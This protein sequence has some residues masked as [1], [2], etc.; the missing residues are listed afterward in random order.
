MLWDYLYSNAVVIPVWRRMR[1]GSDALRDGRYGGLGIVVGY[2]P[3]QMLL[4]NALPG[5]TGQI[6]RCALF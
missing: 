1:W 4:W 3:M 6:Q 2:H 5:G